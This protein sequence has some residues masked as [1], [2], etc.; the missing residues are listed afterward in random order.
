VDP[1]LAAAGVGV[2]AQVL[3]GLIADAISKGD[4]DRAYQLLK[5]AAAEGNIP[6]PELEQ[7]AAVTLGPSAFEEINLD[8][9]YEQAQ[10]AA[11]D[12]LGQISDEGGLTLTDKANLNRILGETDRA[13]AS[14]NAS[15]RNDMAARGVGG[16]GAELAMQLSGNQAQAQRGAE[17]GLDTAAMAEQR[18]LD[19]IMAR[20]EMAG[21]MRSQEYGE[22]SDAAKA[23]DKINQFNATQKSDANYYNAGLGQQDYNNRLAAADRRRAGNLDMA[24]Y[25]QNEAQR[26]SHMAGQT[27]NAVAYGAGAYGQYAAGQKKKDEDDE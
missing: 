23:K 22:K 1:T 15:V 2:A 3:S 24:N 16:S 20:G 25:Y 13:A 9:R 11:L 18:A 26:K 8:P 21:S 14:Q 6:A 5:Q 12:K 19:A 27:G 10:F 7:V 17:A 4:R